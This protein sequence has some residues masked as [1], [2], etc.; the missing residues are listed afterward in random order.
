MSSLERDDERRAVNLAPDAIAR[1]TFPTS[2]RGY[3][4]E[5]VRVFLERV[6]DELREAR[7]REAGLR[8]ELEAVQAKLAAASR[9]DENQLTA[10][11]G[12]ETARVLT[13]AREAAAEMKSKAS[14]T[15]AQTRREAEEEASTLRSDAESLMTRRTEE[16]EAEAA[17]IRAEADATVEALQ[18]EAD[19]ALEAARAD[20][21]RIRIEAEESGAAE[22][23]AAKARGR[24]M[25]DEALLVRARVLEDL[26]RKRKLSRVQIERLQAGRERLIESYA[27]VQRT[28]DDAN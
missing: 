18:A 17:R 4:A 6:A 26:A 7:D 14:D 28:L 24:E 20:A 10:A 2:F 15:A 5:H 8:T 27:I 25:I 9:L 12:E 3:D 11:L 22:V 16:A 13:V 1:T 21:D 19:R 23:E